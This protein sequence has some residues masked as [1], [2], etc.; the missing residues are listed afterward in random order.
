[1]VSKL[2]YNA[3]SPEL[4]RILKILMATE[5]FKDFRLAGGTALCLYRGHRESLDIDMFTD[6]RYGS[7][8][9]DAIDQLLRST[10]SYTDKSEYSTLGPGN[11]YFVGKSEDKCVKLDLFYTD[12][13]IREELISDGIRM[14]A[15]DEIIAM[16]IEAITNGGRK[17]DFWDIHELMDDYTLEI[18]ISLHKER[19]PYGH[20]QAVIVNSLTDFEKADEDFDPIC[21]KEKH[22][23]IIK[24]DLIDFVKGF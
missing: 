5:E 4:L 16:K 1:M 11:S 17:K 9:F 12:T 7:I 21:L 10:F 19:Y 6:A 18:M 3:V 2:H 23:E 8:D 22:W 15:E 14:A 24:L 20:N 13:F